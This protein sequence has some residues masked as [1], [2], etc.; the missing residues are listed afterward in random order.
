MVNHFYKKVKFFSRFFSAVLLILSTDLTVA[1]PITK[2]EAAEFEA[3]VRRIMR[4]PPNFD[5]KTEAAEREKKARAGLKKNPE[6]G[7]LKRDLADALHSLGHYAEHD[8]DYPKALAYHEESLKLY[9][10]S[11]E[12]ESVES[13][14][15]VDHAKEHLFLD[16]YDTAVLAEQNGD[17]AKAEQFF[18][19]SYDWIVKGKLLECTAWQTDRFVPRYTALL[20]RREAKAQSLSALDKKTS[21]KICALFLGQAS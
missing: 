18:E 4:V 5:L 14:N 8:H 1:D 13:W 19:Q 15:G 7:E 10:Q 16:L 21:K 9:E 2:Q 17:Q 11:T 20:K 3:H 12:Y 6:S